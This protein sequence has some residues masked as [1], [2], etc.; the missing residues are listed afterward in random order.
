MEKSST[1]PTVLTGFGHKQ[2]PSRARAFRTERDVPAVLL[3]LIVAIALFGAPR[4]FAEIAVSADFP[5]GSIEVKEI[6]QTTSVL[7]LMPALRPERGWPAWWYARLD[8]L[9]P[10]ERVTVHIHANPRTFIPAPPFARVLGAEWAQPAQAVISADNTTWLQTET[11]TQVERA[12]KYVFVASAERMWIAWGPP[13][14]LEHAHAL[15]ARVMRAPTTQGFVLAKTRGG[16]DVPGVSIGVGPKAVWVQARQ[17]AWEAGGSW[18]GQGFIEW[19]AGND[20][21]AEALRQMA[22]VYFVPIMDVDN[23]MLGA[24]G[25]ESMPQDHNRDWSDG[26]H[27]PEVAAAQKRLRDLDASGALR[28]FLDLHNPGPKD[29][30]PFFFGPFPENLNTPLRIKNY[31]RWHETAVAKIIAPLPMEPRYRLAAYVKTEEERAR[32]SAAWVRAHCAEQVISAAFETP[33][34]TPQ[35]TVDG[36]QAVGRQLAQ[37][38]AAYLADAAH[39]E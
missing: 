26:P 22:T 37:A 28:V 29:M 27:Y 38:L 23:V 2:S 1:Q 6:E 18:V 9:K 15:L 39:G 25:K 30:R 10:G 31:A 35:S 17:H 21:A 16:V 34:N 13:F 12:R 36:Y 32:V 24:G 4:A 8:G 3:R 5:G 19:V 33:W 14:V 20:P 7:H 11:G